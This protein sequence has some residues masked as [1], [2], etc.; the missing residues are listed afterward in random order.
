MNCDV[1]KV[2]DQK[3]MENKKVLNRVKKYCLQRKR[4]TPLIFTIILAYSV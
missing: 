3:I 2:D 1:L 4:N